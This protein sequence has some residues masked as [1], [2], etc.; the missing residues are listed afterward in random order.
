[1][2]PARNARAMQTDIA[3]VIFIFSMLLTSK[4]QFGAYATILCIVLLETTF[5]DNQL[6]L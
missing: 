1:V 4:S 2:Q 3:L 6:C 5:H